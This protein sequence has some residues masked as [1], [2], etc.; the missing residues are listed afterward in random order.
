MTSSKKNTIVPGHC[1]KNIPIDTF[2]GIVIHSSNLDTSTFQTEWFTM[3]NLQFK[4]PKYSITFD[5]FF[6]INK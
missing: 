5:R 6:I 2:L 3:P 1:R 4:S